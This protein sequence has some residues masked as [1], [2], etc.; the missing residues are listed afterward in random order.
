MLLQQQQQG[1]GQGLG[2][3][4]VMGGQEGGAG[5]KMLYG[6]HMGRQQQMMVETGGPIQM[7]HMTTMPDYPLLGSPGGQGL[8]HLGVGIQTMPDPSAL[9]QPQADTY[10][11]RMLGMG[12]GITPHPHPA[13]G[14]NSMAYPAGGE[15]T[16][17][18]HTD[19]FQNIFGGVV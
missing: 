11:H 17:P 9:R 2:G 5:G 4:G 12:M 16:V 10:H 7:H 18:Q 19:C 1:M 14:L 8:D 13:L 15:E 6:T 3:M